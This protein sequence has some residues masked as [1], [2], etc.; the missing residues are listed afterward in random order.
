MPSPGLHAN[1]LPKDLQVPAAN[2]IFF[3]HIEYEVT[4]DS[5]RAKIN[6]DYKKSVEAT[7]AD[8]HVVIT[9]VG[10]SIT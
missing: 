1:F 9:V 7:C 3:V 5:G 6:H 4:E 2:A 8:Q 10:I